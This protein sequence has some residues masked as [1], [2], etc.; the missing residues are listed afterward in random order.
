MNG[1]LGYDHKEAPHDG[2]VKGHQHHEQPFQLEH[3][4][5]T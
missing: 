1:E 3:D 5:P 4:P 2:A